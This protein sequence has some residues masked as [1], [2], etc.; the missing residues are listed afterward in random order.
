LNHRQVQISG[1]SDSVLYQGERFGNFSYAIPVAVESRYDVTLHFCEGYFVHPLPGQSLVGARSFD[2]YLNG[3]KLLND[4]D[5]FKTAGS[6]RAL[7]R[8]FTDLQPNAQG[9]LQISFVPT[10]NYATVSA[11]EVIDENWR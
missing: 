11:I 6:L 10:R 9:K 2:V 4:L 1:A 5:I 3:R 7:D 8:T